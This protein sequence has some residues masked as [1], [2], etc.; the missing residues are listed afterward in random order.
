M[1]VYCAHWRHHLVNTIERLCAAS[2]SGYAA[3]GCDAACSQITLGNLVLDAKRSESDAINTV[4][5]EVIFVSRYYSS[6][7]FNGL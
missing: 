5:R 3:K 7:D 2:L 1:G 6:V 4:P